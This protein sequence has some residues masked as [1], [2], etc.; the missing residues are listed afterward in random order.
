MKPN[1]GLQLKLTESH[2]ASCGHALRSVFPVESLYWVF[3]QALQP[4]LVLFFINPAMHLK[5]E[6]S[7]Q[8]A[9]EGHATHVL[10]STVG[11]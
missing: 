1:P 11:L 7:W 6:V 2:V 4:L 9:F 3:K 8:T 5:D 10:L